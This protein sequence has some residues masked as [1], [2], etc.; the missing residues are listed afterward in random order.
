[1]AVTTPF[2]KYTYMSLLGGR[3]MSVLKV[4]PGTP[5]IPWCSSG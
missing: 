2:L 4:F 5:G 1:M 3:D